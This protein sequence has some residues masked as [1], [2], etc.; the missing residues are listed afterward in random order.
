MGAGGTDCGIFRSWAEAR[1]QVRI[2]GLIG[3]VARNER[4]SVRLCG[5]GLVEVAVRAP[6]SI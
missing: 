5:A 2:E 4:F 3:W 6:A 1:P